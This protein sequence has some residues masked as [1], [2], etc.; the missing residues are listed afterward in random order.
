MVT[1]SVLASLTLLA[2]PT[3]AEEI[4]EERVVVLLGELGTALGDAGEDCDVVARSLRDWAAR[5]GT[6]LRTLAEATKARTEPLSSERQ[7]ELEQQL[8]P[9]ME[10]VF[11]VAMLCSEHADTTAAFEEL[12]SLLGADESK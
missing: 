7:H 3:S 5:N 10:Q 11:R 1:C 6:E 8:Q 12:E 4:P 9:A 2:A